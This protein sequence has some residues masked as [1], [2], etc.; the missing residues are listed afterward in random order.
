MLPNIQNEKELANMCLQMRQLYDIIKKTNDDICYL[1]VG[2]T[3][4][5]L[6]AIKNGSNMIRVGSG[7]FG[8]RNY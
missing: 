7:I 1:S 3:N 6:I 5:Y 4:D 8:N 2:M